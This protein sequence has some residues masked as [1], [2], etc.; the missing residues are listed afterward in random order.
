[1]RTPF[2]ER[3][4]AHA[5]ARAAEGERRDQVAMVRVAIWLFGVGGVMG[6]LISFA[7]RGADGFDHRGMLIVAL[8]SLAVAATIFV[9]FDK[10]PDWSAH[11]MT[12]MGTVLVTASIYFTGQAPSAGAMLYVW[13]ALFSFYFL[14]RGWAFAQVA[15]IAAGYGLIVLVRQPPGSPVGNW[16]TTVA[17][18]FVAGIVV[19]LLKERVERLIGT[20]GDAARTDDLTGLLNRRGF[21]ERFA[22][23]LERSRREGRPLALLLGDLD[24]FKQVN[25][26][27]G[28]H[29][30][31]SALRTVSEVLEHSTRGGD[32]A[33]RIGGEEF[34]IIV[35][36]CDEERATALAERARGDVERAF[37]DQPV[38]L[39]ISFGIACFPQHGA[40][41]QEILRAA[42]RALYSA[43]ELGRNRSAVTGAALPEEIT[44]VLERP[45][46]LR[47]Y[48]Q[49]F[50]A[51]ATGHVAGY[52][53]LARFPGE[54]ARPPNVWFE[55]AHDCG[56]GAELEAH[57]VA[58]ALAEAGR[59]RGTLLSL[60]LSP[61]VISS[62][63]VM[64]A[65]PTSL[66]GLVIEIT[67]QELISDDGLLD[68]GLA[69]LRDRGALIAIDDAGSGYA[70][71]QR[72]MRVQPDMIKLDRALIENVHA[73]PDK[74]ALIES[75]VR[76]ARRTGAT[77]CAEGIESLADMT[78]LAD[79]DVTYGQGFALARPAPA[80]TLPTVE[81]ADACRQAFQAAMERP[82][83]GDSVA[84]RLAQASSIADLGP[85][86]ELIAA[87]LAA[88]E[89][90]YSYWSQ[91]GGYVE[92]AE[93]VYGPGVHGRFHLS[94]Y[95]ATARVLEGQEALQI[96]IGDPKS[97]PAEVKLLLE[98]EGYRACLMLP[99]VSQGET[100]GLLEAWR[101]EERPWSRAEISRGRAICFHLGAVLTG[102]AGVS[103]TAA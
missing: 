51:L 79:L 76:F 77:V 32:V 30:G 41:T 35:A 52:E 58:A 11:V 72:L 3:L 48:F 44:D 65:L 25:D 1:M 7:V 22:A 21:H 89:A 27:F 23:D 18:L 60:N 43:K 9:G 103:R 15:F 64:D 95:P 29:A 74:A 42:D 81:A 75:F 83:P 100:L 33:A 93:T 57:A 16:F 38:P 6:V 2:R 19:A 96:L 45:D 69:Q 102:L 56:L 70:G 59:P 61:S 4:L 34:A 26:R 66:D 13:T 68:S 8:A 12:A 82:T 80:W 17:T 10:W 84:A 5:F 63:P 36:D 90:E 85:V 101:R 94:D 91:A 71:L 40:T 53:A 54:P 49:P 24:Q 86:M 28:H 87:E 92:T 46:S 78:A 47:M 62:P 20:L 88:D 37:A 99:V 50:V 31:D 67:E 97:D 98:S 39:T 14:P 55:Q 73:D